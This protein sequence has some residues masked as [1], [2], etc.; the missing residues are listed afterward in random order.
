MEPDSYVNGSKRAGAS[1]EALLSRV[2][3]F[4][5]ASA[6]AR[7]SF[8]AA[9][10]RLVL[11]EGDRAWRAG[12]PSWAFAF[13]ARGIIKLSRPRVGGRADIIGIFGPGE[14]IGIVAAL[15][16]HAYPADAVTASKE[17]E[18]IQIPRIE[19]LHVSEREIEFMKGL[20][21]CCACRACGM[22]DMNTVLT[23]GGVESR[24]AA[25]IVSLSERFGDIDEDGALRVPVVLTRAELASCIS[26]TM[27]TV[28][29]TMSRWDADGI[30]ETCDQ[31]FVIR[32]TERLRQYADPLTVRARKSQ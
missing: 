28:I 30:M 5:T 12:D 9:A 21:H 17:A 1:I 27:E 22:R 4:S 19:V 20:A 10:R 24:L 26:S 3:P 6:A 25:L 2:A 11:G 13:V 31:G 16:G 14:A 23:A 18:I 7:T 32:S 29:R 15:R 8:A